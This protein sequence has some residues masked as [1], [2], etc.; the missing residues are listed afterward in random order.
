[1]LSYL[2]Q[3]LLILQRKSEKNCAK[4]IFHTGSFCENVCDTRVHAYLCMVCVCV[5][6]CIYVYMCI[7]IGG[8]IPLVTSSA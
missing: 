1:M 2:C 7:G 8:G 6:V 3:H 5:Y 4:L